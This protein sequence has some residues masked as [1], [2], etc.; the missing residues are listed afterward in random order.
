MQICEYFLRSI[1]GSIVWY[2][3]PLVQGSSPDLNAYYLN[4]FD[5]MRHIEKINLLG[6]HCAIGGEQ[7]GCEY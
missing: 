7:A 1:L 6:K 3:A 4:K 5:I 2:S